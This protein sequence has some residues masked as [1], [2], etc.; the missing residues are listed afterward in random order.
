MARIRIV[1]VVLAALVL[2]P[3]A[4]LVHRT[5]EG[6]DAEREVQHR[7]VADR[8]FD[9]M[10]SE[11]SAFLLEEEMRPFDHYR[12][13]YTPQGAPSAQSALVR[14]PLSKPPLHPWVLGYFQIDPDE[15]FYTPMLPR[16]PALALQRG[17]WEESV[18]SIERAREIEAIVQASLGGD[19]PVEE[20]LVPGG[21]P[22]APKVAHEPG[23]TRDQRA[24]L[25]VHRAAFDLRES[26]PQEVR[27]AESADEDESDT[28]AAYKAIRSLNRGVRKRPER[29]SKQMLSLVFSQPEGRG[30]VTVTATVEDPETGE[31]QKVGEASLALEAGSSHPLSALR[32]PAARAAADL[33]RVEVLPLMAQLDGAGHMVLSRPV[34][35]QRGSYRQGMVLDVYGLARWLD[36][37]VLAGNM[38][39]RT[40]RREFFA[41]AQGPPP[42]RHADDFVYVHRFAVPLDAMGVQLSMTPLRGSRRVAYVYA[43]AVLLVLAG[44][45]GLFAVY[46]MVAVTVGFAE[47]RSNFVAAVSHELKTPLTAIRMYSEMLR[48]GMVQ[49]E[50]KRREYTSTITNE[51]ERLTRLIN[52]VLEFSHLEQGTR[53]LSLVAG[54][55][56][57]VVEEAARI[58]EPHAKQVGFRLAV[59]VEPGLPSVRFDRDAVLQVVFNLVDNGLKYA[60][61]AEEP[62]V[63]LRCGRRDGGVVL[64]V[65]DH[66]PGVPDQ[67][68]SKVFEAFY[69]GGDEMTRTA[70]GTGI[71]LALVKGLAERMG[72]VVTGR[73]VDEG[74]FEVSLRFQ[75]ASAD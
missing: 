27:S 54:A 62:V 32:A 31:I 20:A 36:E 23:T 3:M 52:N 43:I 25:P 21:A 14:S 11:I 63:V 1:F 37:R 71:G 30:G 53:D 16:M 35:S 57:P 42:P 2:L 47:R 13:Y 40:A 39:Q 60:R 59:E 7:A 61:G 22:S 72:A 73:N 67:H 15:R 55:I 38:L 34:L 70:K 74:G 64:S 75:S 5:L 10:E 12:F 4:L 33:G 48:D 29:T 18:A 24:P 9:E 6:I 46:R 49:G 58:L 65:R 50:E 45:V 68:L 56:G 8:I 51:C 41:F 17:D 26:S 69:R 28:A 66:G 19:R 44:S